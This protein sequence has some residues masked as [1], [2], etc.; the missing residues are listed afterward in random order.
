[1]SNGSFT[2]GVAMCRLSFASVA[3]C[4]LA[5]RQEALSSFGGTNFFTKENGAYEGRRQAAQRDFHLIVYLLLVSWYR[6]RVTEWISR[7]SCICQQWHTI[8]TRF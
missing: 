4:E 1:M 5:A 8:L 7:R 3:V 2:F 6:L